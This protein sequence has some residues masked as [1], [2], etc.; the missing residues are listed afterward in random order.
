[1]LD[2]AG[3]GGGDRRA[4]AR[5]VGDHAVGQR[6]RAAV[7]QM[8]HPVLDRRQRAP[9]AHI[10][11][12]RRLAEIGVRDLPRAAPAP[13][14]GGERQ[15]VERPDP[16][17]EGADIGLLAHVDGMAA[18]ARAQPADRRLDVLRIARAD[19]H[20]GAI[21]Q[22]PGGDGEADARRASDDDDAFA[23]KPAAHLVTGRMTTP[24][25]ST[26]PAA[27]GRPAALARSSVA[28][29]SLTSM[30]RPTTPVPS[31]SRGL[32]NR[33]SPRSSLIFRVSPPVIAFACSSSHQRSQAPTG[34]RAW[35][36]TAAMPR[37]SSLWCL[38]H[39]GPAGG[40]SLWLSR[41]LASPTTLSMESKT[42][43]QSPG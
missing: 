34:S 28:W 6:D 33:T 25:I 17:E 16:L 39:S 23:R 2:G 21:R 42:P 37:L 43:A 12:V 40:H 24:Q 35:M 19:H 7:A 30:S 18:G 5:P 29:P 1:M 38:R 41:Q 10:E 32:T 4:L 20:L 27:T 3:H 14:A 22:R 15:V 9:E 8:L 31:S 11:E 13:V 36:V 26:A